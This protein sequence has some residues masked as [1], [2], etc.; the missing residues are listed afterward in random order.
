[1]SLGDNEAG[2]RILINRLLESAGWRFEDSAEGKANIKLESRVKYSDLGDDFENASS[3][4]KSGQMDFLLLDDDKKPLI[5][6]EAKR[7][8]MQP[9]AG[10]EQARTYAKEVA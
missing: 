10:K 4:G 2:A 8:S 5:V 7:K 9:L 3:R 1:M 6:L